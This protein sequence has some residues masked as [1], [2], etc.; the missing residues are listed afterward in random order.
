MWDN[1]LLGTYVDT[2]EFFDRV[3]RDDFLE[4]IIPIVALVQN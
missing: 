1:R 3:E 2:P 4:Q